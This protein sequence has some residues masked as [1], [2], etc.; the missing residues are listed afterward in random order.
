MHHEIRPFRVGQG[1][2]EEP[3]EQRVPVRRRQHLV[4]GVGL[5]AAVRTVR[6]RQQMQIVVSQHHDRVVAE[7]AHPP[8]RRQ[9]VGAA[10]D[11]IPD[12]PQAIAIR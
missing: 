4:Q 3:L 1:A 6:E 5:A 9:R 8:Q 12:E 10:V 2:R 11:Q 7:C